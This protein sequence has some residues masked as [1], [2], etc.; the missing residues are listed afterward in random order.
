MLLQAL[1]AVRADD[2]TRSAPQYEPTI[3]SRFFAVPSRQNST[4]ERS[5]PW[6]HRID[7][8]SIPATRSPILSFR[9]A[10][11]RSATLPEHGTG[12]WRVGAIEPEDPT[13]GY[14]SGLLARDPD[15]HG[16]LLVER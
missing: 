4:S 1:F 16:L 9:L 10:H 13:L 7:P 3:T 2:A 5:K 12:P 14:E 6:L 15:G 11:G 8:D